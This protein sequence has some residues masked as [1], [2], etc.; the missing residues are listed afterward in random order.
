MKP[1]P[2]PVIT[3]Y[4]KSYKKID[5]YTFQVETVNP[6]YD[7]VTTLGV[8]TWGSAFNI[9]PK[10]IFEKVDDWTKFTF[11]DPDKGWPVTTLVR[12]T[13]M[14]EDGKVSADFPGEYLKRT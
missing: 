12:G 2:L 10:H 7:F 5:N 13:P 6:A 14:L 3:G 11:Y 4:V 9:V 8:Y 1:A